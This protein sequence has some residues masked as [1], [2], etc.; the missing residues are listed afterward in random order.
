M[1]KNTQKIKN[2]IYLIRPHHYIKNIFI[3]LP[4]FFSGQFIN[5]SQVLNGFIA[6]VA[7]SVSASAI[8]IFNDY[9]DIKNDRKHPKKKYRPLASGSI[10]KS[11]SLF[12]MIIFLITGIFAMYFV[13]INSLIILI[14]YIILNLLYSLKLKQI[15]LLDIYIIS[16]GFVLRLYVGSL[17]YNVELESWI[18]IMTFLL[19]LFLALAKRRDD[20]LILD[21]T[22]TKMR[23]SIEGYN[24]K[25]IDGSMF[26]MSS[27]I[28]VAYLQYTTSLKIIE[29]FNNENLYLTTLFVIFGI[30]RYMQITLV[31]KKSGSPTEVI[32]K[33][34]IIQI[35]LVLW[36][37]SFALIIYN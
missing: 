20:V 18:I 11:S 16:L 9:M 13:S 7:F 17:A 36:I 15:S 2:L 28:I 37:S 22:K 26:V 25:L 34:K 32:L 23:K 31:K 19:A 1:L 10:K 14:I 33:D 24:L 12:L 4:L 21:N 3:F 35:N 5:T 30:M 27:V 29:K 6:F 8:Y